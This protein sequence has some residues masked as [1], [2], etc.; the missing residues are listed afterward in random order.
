MEQIEAS[1]VSVAANIAEGKEGILTKNILSSC[2]IPWLLYETVTLLQV[3]Q[4]GNGY[5]NRTMP[6]S[7]RSNIDRQMLN[8]LIR[9]VRNRLG[10]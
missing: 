9:S 10:E 8:A 7:K 3:F 6:I 1:G 2:T 4:N 5:L